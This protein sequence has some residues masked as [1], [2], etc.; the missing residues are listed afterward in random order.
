MALNDQLSLSE[1]NVIPVMLRIPLQYI[2][3]VQVR[4]LLP[5]QQIEERLSW[6]HVLA[7]ASF[8]GAS[9]SLPEQDFGIDGTF[10]QIVSLGGR[11][12]PSGNALD[13]QLKAST[14]CG[15][16]PDHIIYDLD[17]KTYN[18][19]IQRD[20]IQYAVPCILILKVLPRDPIQWITDSEVGL[21]LNGGCYWFYIQGQPSSNQVT[22]RIRIPRTQQLTSDA[23]NYL[24]ERSGME[25]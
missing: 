5:S 14:R 9:I 2:G 25:E 19:L 12:F 4:V 1:L 23:L 8:A 24:L 11:L 18:A 13:F 21:L 16:E 22:V 15:I 3:R 10:R 20:L 7:I 6:T 17:V